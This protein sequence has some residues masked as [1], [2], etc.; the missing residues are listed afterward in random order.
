MLILGWVAGYR[1]AS[2]G[3]RRIGVPEALG[4]SCVGVVMP[5][6]SSAASGPY[7]WSYIEDFRL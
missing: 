4:C 3:Q 1:W 6:S 2:G 5:L 7:L